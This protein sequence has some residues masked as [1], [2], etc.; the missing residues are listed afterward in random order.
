MLQLHMKTINRSFK[1]LT[2]ERFLQIQNT[3][4]NVMKKLSKLGIGSTKRQADIITIEEENT[5]WNTGVLGIDTPQKLVSTLFYVIGLNYALRGG[6]EHRV[7]RHGSLS[8]FKLILTPEGKKCLQYTESS[9]KSHQG[10]LADYNKKRKC[11]KVEAS[12]DKRNVV[13]IYE[14]YIAHCPKPLEELTGFYL[15]PLQKP[16]SEVWF[17]KQ[18]SGRHKLTNMVRE[19]CEMGNLGGYRTNHSLRSTCATRLYEADVDEQVITEITGHQSNAIRNYKRTSD[20]K[21]R[22]ICSIVQGSSESNVGVNNIPCTS[23]KLDT[24]S[25][26]MTSNIDPGNKGVSF[27]INLNVN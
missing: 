23:L 8:Q 21:R 12:D 17:S 3:L 26:E 18:P 25:T 13:A 14:C 24:T 9:S 10:G 22:K 6:E 4:D 20:A 1:F 15:R 11:W 27:T 16:T 5:L 7:L 19:I 2:D